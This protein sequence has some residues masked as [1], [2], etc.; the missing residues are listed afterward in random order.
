[1]EVAIIYNKKKFYEFNG[2]NFEQRYLKS[3]K[4]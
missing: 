1:M 2:S 4:T 3:I